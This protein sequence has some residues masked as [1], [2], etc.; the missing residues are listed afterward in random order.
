[1]NTGGGVCRN[2][3][4]DIE[5]G[6]ASTASGWL[7]AKLKEGQVDARALGNVVYVMTSVMSGHETVRR[8]EETIRN[9]FEE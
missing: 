4:A 8:L 7:L 5:V 9:C 6:Y 3:V 2:E 1:V